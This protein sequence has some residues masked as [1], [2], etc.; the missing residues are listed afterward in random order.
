VVVVS[1][2]GGASAEGLALLAEDAGGAEVILVYDTDNA[3][4]AVRM[5]VD[6]TV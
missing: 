6:L 3:A 2:P 1:T 4:Q 5:R